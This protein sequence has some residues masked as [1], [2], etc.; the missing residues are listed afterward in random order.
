M[1]EGKKLI[2]SHIFI[3]NCADNNINND[4]HCLA[5]HTRIT[6]ER[7]L[8]TQIESHLF[9]PMLTTRITY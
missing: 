6:D 4:Y 8:N 5:V 7:A 1:A 9:M 2:P 3:T